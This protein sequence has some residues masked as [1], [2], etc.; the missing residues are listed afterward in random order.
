MPIMNRMGELG[1][2]ILDSSPEGVIVSDRNGNIVYANAAYTGILS[3]DREKRVGSNILKFN[4]HGALG[5]VLVT[6]KPVTKRHRPPGLLVEVLSRAFPIYI[7]NKL[8]GAVVFFVELKEALELLRELEKVRQDVEILSN[9]LK[10]LSRVEHNFDSIIGQSQSLKQ[11]I[12]LGEKVALTESTILLRGETGTGK[13]LF[14]KAIHNASNRSSEPF[15]EVNCAAIPENLLESEF[16][17]YEKGSFTGAGHRKMGTFELANQGTIFLDE[18]GDMDLRLQAK[19]LQVLQSGEFRR[20]GGTSPLTVNVRVI[21]ATNRD[22]EGLINQRLFRSDL[23]FRLNVISL[24]I[25]PLRERQGDINL[26]TQYFLLK[27]SR[28][29]GKKILGIKPEA[30]RKLEK[31]HWPGNVRELENVIEKAI[32]ICDHNQWIKEDHIYLSSLST[33]E[34]DTLTTLEELEN[35]MI[36][37]ALKQFGSSVCGKKKAADVLGISLTTLYNKVKKIQNL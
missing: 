32:I 10:D 14:A 17:G 29:V 1:R 12:A 16:F 26:L 31:Y 23:Y 37:K 24:E 30:I 8:V 25:P 22:L 11:T 9:K 20:I 28:R 33:V 18:I 6:G 15:V 19:L 4:P 36:Q 21:A 3:C 13:Q 27:I 34:E 35:H 7:N 2:A 5:E